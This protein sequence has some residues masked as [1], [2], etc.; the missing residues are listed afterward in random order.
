MTSRRV[1]R[2]HGGLLG[3]LALVGL[4][5]LFA[6]PL[7]L[8]ATAV[9]LGFV[10]YGALSTVPGDAAVRIERRFDDAT[11]APGERVT[12]RLAV[13]NAGDA[14]LS[15]LRVVDGVP[16]ELAVVGGSPRTAASLRA[17]E[18]VERTYTVVARRGE[19]GFED[20]VVRVRSLSGSVVHT[21]V[22]PAAGEERLASVNPLAEAPMGHTTLLRAGTHPT[23]SGGDGIEFRSTR[24]YRPGDPIS[25]IHWRQYAKTRELT[26]VSFREER[27]VR[28]VIVA[29]ARPVGRVTPHRGSPT[30]TEL[31]GYAAAR[32]YNALTAADVTTSV[33]AV[34]LDAADGVPGT[35]DLAWADGEADDAEALARRVFDAVQT[36]PTASADRSDSGSTAGTE[37]PG[38]RSDRSGG[39]RK[40]DGR[41][42]ATDGGSARTRRALARFPPTAQVVFVT[43]L[44]DDWPVEFVRTVRERG[45]PVTVVSPDVTG[46]G[47]LGNAV[48]GMERADRLR[49]VAAAGGT[50]IGWQP[51]E[52]IDV[53][54][55]ESLTHLLSS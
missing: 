14:T 34:G 40:R 42:P 12:V 55:T 13:E 30:G 28:T 38:A 9:P 25:R 17:G 47:S 44:L 22:V 24:E 51:A 32:L 23:D 21:A 45:Y 8:A 15:D 48:L 1:Y 46:S 11:P 36:A 49:E 37:Q 53:A 31:C 7:L 33:A 50:T 4:G 26:T 16:E 18:S 10:V 5:V 35:G 29:D 2:W 20:P 27:A 52:P 43:P 19:Y 41:R 6:S 54:L 3:A 39:T